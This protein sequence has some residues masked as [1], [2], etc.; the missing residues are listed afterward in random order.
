MPERLDAYIARRGFGSRSEAKTLI[1]HGAVTISGVP[2]RDPAA[3]VEGPVA[4]HGAEVVEGPDAATLLLNKPLGYACSH[5]EREAPL[6]EELIPERFR[7]LPLEYAGRLDRE[8]SGMLVVTTDGQLIHRLTNPKRHVAKRYRITYRGGLSVHASE[9][10]AAGMVLEGDP[11]PTL[12][13]QLTLDG[14]DAD[15]DGLATMILHEGRYHQVRKMIAACGGE[16]VKLRR[17]RIGQLDLPADLPA[18]QMREMTAEQ[19]AAMFAG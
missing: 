13:A 3:A 4:V 19:I 6:V 10:C 16:V 5:D 14:S 1:R 17:D 15:G 9:R 18:G 2:C 11:R 7:Q 12:P 8:T